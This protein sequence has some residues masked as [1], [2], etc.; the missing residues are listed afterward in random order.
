[1]RRT[2]FLQFIGIASARLL[3]VPSTPF[4]ATDGTIS[5]TTITSIIVDSRHSNTTDTT[6]QT[7]IPPTLL[8]FA[9]TFASDLQ[10]SLDQSTVSVIEGT[11][12]AAGS[13][14]LTLDDSTAY[15]D[16]AGR[17]TAEGYSLSV[18][19]SGITIAGAS[20][21]GAWWGTRSLIQAAVL[22]DGTIKTGSATDAPGWATRGVMLDGGR[23]YYPPE[24]VIEICSYL[25]F[26]KQ[27]TFQLHLSDNLLSAYLNN[28]EYELGLYAAFRLDSDD[29]AVAGL[30]RWKN[31]SYTRSV[32]DNMQEKCA[33]RGVTILPE[34]ETPGHSLVITQWKP[35][36]ALSTD[37]T[38]LNISNPDTIPTVKT[39]W[40][41]FLPWFYSKTVHI[42]ADEYDSKLADDYNSFVREM[43]SFIQA[44]SGFTKKM[45]IWGT[46]PPKDNYTNISTD[47]SI[48]HWEFFEDN[49]LFDYILNNYTVLNSDDAFYIVGKYSASYPQTPNATRIFHG[50]PSVPGGGP[51]APNIFDI[52]N[53]TNNPPRGEPL[54][55]GHLAAQWNDYGPNA[56]TVTEAYYAWRDLLPALADKQWGGD[57]SQD[58]YLSIFETLHA[59]IP[60]QNL[61]RSIESCSSTIIKYDFGKA[62]DGKVPD[63]SGNGYD[64][65]TD[66]AIDGAAAAIVLDGTCALHT[67]LGSKG[68]NYTLS[69]TV[70]PSD[71]DSAT[72]LP[73]L[74]TGPDSVLLAG[75]DANVTLLSG[76]NL[77]ALNYSFPVDTWTEAK[78][79]GQG[80]QTFLHVREG[81][82][83]GQ[84]GTGTEEWVSHEFLTTIGILGQ[85]FVWKGIAV[86]APL[87]KVGGETG[88]KG[89]VGLLKGLEVL[90]E[91]VGSS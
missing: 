77:F 29:E 46:F 70:K 37:Y 38:M 3:T 18:T 13:I 42:G 20:P 12:S 39:I 55:L 84:S 11:S 50:D 61:D 21:L 60:G 64:G 89:F 7:L 52:N 49:P 15:L 69:F 81:E 88:G 68:R 40:R 58:E 57:L 67:P 9:E 48:Q 59:A 33:Q 26:F 65:H 41:T 63:L 1:M 85:S 19:S 66:C 73:P 53:A 34:I 16:A 51:Y 36:L 45:R 83:D 27:N 80:N 8:Q 35:E 23:H 78:L 24:F 10:S 17:H 28:S 6:G 4:E 54:V 47:V 31:E 56:T 90:D 76:G 71:T 2:S 30:N 44:E 5:L 72:A 62:K 87:T 22:G 86:E 82:G 43:D 91:V 14:F 25:S 75:A 74:F 32:F 79:V